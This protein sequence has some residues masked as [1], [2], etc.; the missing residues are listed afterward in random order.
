[1]KSATLTIFANF[2]I[3]N[4]ERFLRMQDSFLSFKDISAEKW[5][6][7]IRGSYKEDT[8]IFLQKYLKNKL[9]H[10]D[11]ESKEGWFYDTRIMLKDINSDF[12]FF[13][14]ED[15]I[16]MVNISKCDEILDEMRENQCD[17]LC[18]SWWHNNY[19]KTFSSLVVK[20]SASLNIY[21]MNKENIKT[22][23]KNIG[24]Y[25]YII[26]AV[27]ITSTKLF[28]KI[29]SSS[30]PRLKRW[31]KETPF[32]FEKRSTDAEFLPFNLAI[33]KFELFASIDDNHGANGNY[34]LIDRG[35]YPNRISREEMKNLEFNKNQFN[36]NQFKKFIPK[37]FL[38]LFA[39]LYVF[40]D[41]IK[42]TIS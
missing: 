27:S 25:F 21:E 15:H 13:W 4:Q 19:K 8:L 28:K 26:S 29:V 7:N 6:V 1:M 36:K 32:D 12:V 40:I 33:S 24:R 35:L 10:Y 41:R 22:I 11:M 9:Y 18:Y 2:R 17:H 31:P 38:K 30:H 20:E 34:S 39:Y 37:V 5:V 42:Y 23:E 14:I 16:N 3:D